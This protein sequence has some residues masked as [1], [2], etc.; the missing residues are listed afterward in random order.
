LKVIGAAR[1]TVSRAG[2]SK[3]SPMNDLVPT[4][5]SGSESGVVGKLVGDLAT[6]TSLH[7]AAE[8]GDGLSSG[9][10]SIGDGLEVFDQGWGVSTSGLTP[11]SYNAASTPIHTP[12]RIPDSAD[13]AIAPTPDTGVTSRARNCLWLRGQPTNVVR[14]ECHGE[15]MSCWRREVRS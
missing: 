14:Y 6:F 5:R 3:P 11:A 9:L 4:I 10:K 1:N 12:D 15:E 7:A 8:N 13:E 2:Q